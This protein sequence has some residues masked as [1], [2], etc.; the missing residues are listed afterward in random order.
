MPELEN[1][2]FD[3]SK[4]LKPG[5][6]IVATFVNKWYAFDILWNMVMLRPKK[7]MSRLRKVWGGLLPD[8]F[9]SIKMLFSSAHSRHLQETTLIKKHRSG[10]CITHPAWYR[11]HWAPLESIRSK[12][13]VQIRRILT[14]DSFLEFRR[15]QFVHL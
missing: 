7:A 13:L 15:I 4:V 11:H 10:Y 9:F 5:G 1:A 8:S 14:M 2:V 3:M 6:R 12:F